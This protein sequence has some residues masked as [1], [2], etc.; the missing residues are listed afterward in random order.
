MTDTGKLIR[1]G[2]YLTP[3]FRLSF[4][5]LFEARAQAKGKPKFQCSALFAKG[6]D[7]SLLKK[8][9]EDVGVAKWGADKGKWP[10]G[11]VSPFK[12][13]GNKE[14]EGYEAGAIFISLS[15]T[16]RPEVVGPD[17]NPIEE[18]DIYAGCY[19]RASVR[20]FAY[21]YR[22]TSNGPVMTRGISFGLGN[23]QKVRD[24]EPLDSRSFAETDFEAAEGVEAGGTASD[25]F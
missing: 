22:E 21:E 10:K 14:Y 1:P 20:P 8:A 7:L 18:S 13:Q 5:S 23:V 25:L 19:C 15:S 12:D 6:A 24:G 16:Q 17:K 4:P 3:V 2:L 9:A 11:W